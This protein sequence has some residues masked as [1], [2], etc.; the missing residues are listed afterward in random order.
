MFSPIFAAP[1]NTLVLEVNPLDANVIFN[2]GQ[3]VLVVLLV[4]LALCAI[5]GFIARITGLTRLDIETSK[6]TSRFALIFL[7]TVLAWLGLSMLIGYM[8]ERILDIINGGLLLAAM[9]T[10]I[11]QRAMSNQPG[12]NRTLAF[13]F[14]FL[15]VMLL[16]NF[17]YGHVMD[18]LPAEFMDSIGY[19][20]HADFFNDAFRFWGWM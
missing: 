12:A 8:G 11:I 7:Y 1:T 16:W 3:P 6:W 2:I 20:F 17:I 5:I 4:L 13:A 18:A 10:S 19:E 15:A 9:A 14:G